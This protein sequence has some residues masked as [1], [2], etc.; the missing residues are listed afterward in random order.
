MPNPEVVIAFALSG[1]RDGR[2][3][4]FLSYQE[5]LNSAYQD[6]VFALGRE[7]QARV[8]AAFDRKHGRTGRTAK[9]VS[10]RFSPGITGGKGDPTLA[11]IYAVRFEG[12][13]GFVINDLPPHIIRT[14]TKRGLSNQN[15]ATGTA[16]AR[17]GE[18]P[19]SFPMR[20]VQW[21][22]RGADRHFYEDEQP[23]LEGEGLAAM[24]TLAATAQNLWFEEARG[25]VIYKT[26]EF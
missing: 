23:W 24:H 22:P 2:T 12:G 13:I 11:A 1:P 19:W 4:Q 25:E 15:T 5:R 18:F 3:G 21:K 26:G 14:R 17:Y 9:S 8:A 10:N 7:Y 20:Y 16:L 6:R